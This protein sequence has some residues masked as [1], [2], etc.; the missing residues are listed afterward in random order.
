MRLGLAFL[1][2]F[3]TLSAQSNPFTCALK[4]DSFNG[5]NL[6]A[7]ACNV[8]EGWRFVIEDV[9]GTV[10]LPN[11]TF[12]V[13][14]VEITTAGLTRT[15]YLRLTPIGVNGSVMVHTVGE[16]V[17]WYADPGRPVLLGF[18]RIGFGLSAID[19]VVSGY[20]VDLSGSLY[21]R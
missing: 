17:R 15:M 16:M 3:G 7:T 4:R 13:A 19:V 9:R 5:G 21:R 10:S 18:D 20:L 8:P 14:T 6:S 2:C 1:L 12:G 11:G